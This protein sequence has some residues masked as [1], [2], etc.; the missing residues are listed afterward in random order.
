VVFFTMM[1]LSQKRSFSMDKLNKDL[2]REHGH[3]FIRVWTKVS[4]LFPFSQAGNKISCGCASHVSDVVQAF[5][6]SFLDA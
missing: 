2:G 4:V 1:I 5:P 6:T 3:G